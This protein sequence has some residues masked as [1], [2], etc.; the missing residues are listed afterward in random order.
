MYYCQN[1]YSEFEEPERKKECFET[2]YGVDNLFNDRNYF[3]MLICPTCGSDDIEE[4]KECDR[5]G[6]YCLEDDLVDTEE[7]AGGGIGDICPDCARD[8]DLI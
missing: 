2:F 7:L 3:D 1:C 6:E 5:C 4:M 8:C